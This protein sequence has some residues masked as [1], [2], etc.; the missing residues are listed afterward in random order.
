VSLAW[1]WRDEADPAARATIEFAG[2]PYDRQMTGGSF[3]LLPFPGARYAIIGAYMTERY[4]NDEILRALDDLIERVNRPAALSE[5]LL[6]ADDVANLLNIPVKTVRQY[7]RDGR[8]P[9]RRF[10][11]HIRYVRAEI[12]QAIEK[13]TIG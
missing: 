9:C 10:G 5:P 7:A 2:L 13:G 3:D 8:L 11:K 12:A 1:D 6:D 4:S